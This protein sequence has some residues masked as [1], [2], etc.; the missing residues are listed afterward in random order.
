MKKHILISLFI[1]IVM[2]VFAYKD[3]FWQMEMML[4][5]WMYIETKPTD[6]RIIVVGIDDESIQE[7]GTWPWKRS[8]HGETLNIISSGNPAAIGVDI[9]FVEESYSI[10]DD[11]KL[12][13]AVKNAGNVISAGMAVLPESMKAKNIETKEYYAPIKSLSDNSKV[14]HINVIPDR[15]GN[16]RQAFLEFKYR[17]E[18][19]KSFASQIYDTYLEKF[20]KLAQTVKIET[21]DFNRTYIDFIN[22]PD[23]YQYISYTDIFN[24][25]VDSSYFKDKI[26]LIGPYTEGLLDSYYT[27]VDQQT[28]MFGVEV[29]ANI[30]QNFLENRFKTK[31]PYGIEIAIIGLMSII[32]Y[33]IIREQ[34]PIRTFL[35][36]FISVSAY[37]LV[38]RFMFVKGWRLQ[39]VY[40]IVTIVGTYLVDVILKYVR[41]IKRRKS[42]TN[43]FGKYVAPQVVSEII[44][45][46][47]NQLSLG[48]KKKIISVLFVDIRGFTPLSE[49]ATPEEVVEI[50]NDYLELCESA[51]FHN[52]GTLDKFIGDAAMAIYN[53]PLMVENHAFKAVLTAL[54]MKEKSEPL[55]KNL[56]KRFGR[57]VYFG[58]G[59]NTGEAVVGNIGSKQRMDYTAIGDTVN[60]SARL[61]S[62]AK[63]GQILISQSTYD[64]VKDKVDVLDLGYIKVKGKSQE[65]KVY[66]V[67]K[68]K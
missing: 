5:D 13:E 36:V 39:L 6:T 51:V 59:I 63:G 42:I 40:P 54:E 16:I 15:D 57:N 53:A 29:H 66:E 25:R 55:R 41:E 31:I 14:G 20:P 24:K 2:S 28:K 46:G 52:E 67:E 44:K 62:N 26:I 9:L 10:E 11:Y 43:L 37:F 27:S 33:W 48:G 8:V 12:T 68:L 47:E 22:I 3:S 61:E 58:I 19:V 17:D 23:S 65:L 60:T 50:L 30:I 38:I 34:R 35:I 56:E 7:I 64:L 21:D 49:K 4:T 45:A 18:I 32:A 1:F